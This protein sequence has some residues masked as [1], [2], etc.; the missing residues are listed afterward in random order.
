MVQ[1]GAFAI[2]QLS[3]ALSATARSE[4]LPEGLPER[5]LQKCAEQVELSSG[6]IFLN[7][8]YFFPFLTPRCNFSTVFFPFFLSVLVYLDFSLCHYELDP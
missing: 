5:A 2:E 8:S 6:K 4:K 3:E 7:L 1:S